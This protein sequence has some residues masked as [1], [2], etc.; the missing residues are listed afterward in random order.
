MTAREERLLDIATDIRDS[1]GHSRRIY[2]SDLEVLNEI[3][4][5]YKAETLSPEE[6]DEA[7]QPDWTPEPEDIFG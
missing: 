7:L 6:T 4:G 5:E 3:L 2:D 1:A